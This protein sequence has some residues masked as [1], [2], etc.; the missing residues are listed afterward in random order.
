[1]STVDQNPRTS[2]RGAVNAP[3]TPAERVARAQAAL[4][5]RGGRR[6]PSGYL[7]PDAAAALKKLVASGYAPSPVSAISK[8]LLAT[9][10]AQ[11]KP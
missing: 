11:C 2:G 6:M 4:V 5:E 7:Q 3:L 1:M 10:A 8:A 9:A